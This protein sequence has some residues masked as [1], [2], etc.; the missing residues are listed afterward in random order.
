MIKFELK[1]RFKMLTDN[2]ILVFVLKKLNFN[3][4][5]LIEVTQTICTQFSICTSKGY[6]TIDIGTFY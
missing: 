6:I 5:I 2:I 1:I 3:R 4:V